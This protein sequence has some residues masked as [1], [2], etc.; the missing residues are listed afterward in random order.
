MKPKKLKGTSK[1]AEKRKSKTCY[2]SRKNSK[3]TVD[4]RYPKEKAKAITEAEK[5]SKV[6][7]K[8][9]QKP[10][11]GSARTGSGAHTTEHIT[12]PRSKTAVCFHITIDIEKALDKLKQRCVINTKDELQVRVKLN[13]TRF[14][15]EDKK[16]VLLRRGETASASQ[17]PDWTYRVATWWCFRTGY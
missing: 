2:W 5:K 11:L 8:T 3:G 17:E 13:G 16:I 4:T 6:R 12:A 1:D 14:I 9:R 15:N 10:T 7:Q